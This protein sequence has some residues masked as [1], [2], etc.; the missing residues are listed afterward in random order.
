MHPSS[1]SM[2]AP[3]DQDE[4]EMVYAAEET[5]TDAIP[6]PVNEQIATLEQEN[7]ALKDRLLRTLAEMDNL[8]KRTER[9][10]ADA[11]AYALT[12]FARD[13][14]SVVDNLGRALAASPVDDASD[15]TLTA[16]AEG[17]SM[18]ERELLNALKKHG[19]E[20]VDP[21]NQR[22]DPNL[23]QAIFEIE[24]AN[25]P[26]GTVLQVMQSGFTLSGR[27]LRP[28]MVGVSKG[29]PKPSGE[30]VDRTV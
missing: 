16:L 1:P 9:E 10:V 4:T 6:D 26:A 23:H 19:V 22:F 15:P 13:L 27:V 3:K 7:T 20:R 12:S 30:T 14:L 21:E 11:K 2:N 24:N 29:G 8:R 5:L 17:V 28:A 18:T 25:V